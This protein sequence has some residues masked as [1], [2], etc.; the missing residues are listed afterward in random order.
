MVQQ[1]SSIGRSKNWH[2]Y[3]CARVLVFPR[4]CIM[5]VC[6]CVCARARPH[7]SMCVYYERVGV[8]VCVHA[9]AHV[10]TC[11]HVGMLMCVCVY[12]SVCVSLRV[13]VCVCARARLCE[14]S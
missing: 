1:F 11:R 5:S 12:I 2:V 7:A 10:R 13:Y 8:R 9:R 3:G 4:V 6:V 14:N